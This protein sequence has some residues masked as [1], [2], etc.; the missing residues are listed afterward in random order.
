MRSM[1]HKFRGEGNSWRES[2]DKYLNS[3][4]LA[5]IDAYGTLIIYYEN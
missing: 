4:W 2:Y 5:T 3:F 1:I